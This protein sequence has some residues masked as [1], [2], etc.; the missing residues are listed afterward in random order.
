MYSVK[1]GKTAWEILYVEPVFESLFGSMRDLGDIFNQAMTSYSLQTIPAILAAYDFSGA[2]TI[3]DIAGG[4][5]HVLGAI[6][7]QYPDARGILFDMP[8]VLDDAPAMLESYGVRDR[9]ELVSGDFTEA[10][11]VVA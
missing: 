10:I 5:G 9:V 8:V 11:P 7:R 6:L 1:T 2:Q 3:A 4:Y